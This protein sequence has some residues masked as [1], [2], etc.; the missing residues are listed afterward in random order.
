VGSVDNISSV[1]VFAISKEVAGAPVVILVIT[2]IS[3][4]DLRINIKP[5]AE[6]INNKI[7]NINIKL[8]TLGL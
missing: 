7:K 2:G 3:W 5:T 8:L 1:L 6:I 4:V